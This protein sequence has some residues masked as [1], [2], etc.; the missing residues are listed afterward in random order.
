[1]FKKLLF[2]L[3]VLFCTVSYSQI[4]GKSVY[5]FLNLVTSPRQAALGGKIITN[6]DYDPNAALFNPASINQE[7]HNHLSVN[8]ANYYGE[9]TYGT[10]SYAYTYDR[11]LQTFHA[12]VNYVNYGDFEGVQFGG[13]M[14]K[15]KTSING[16]LT[17]V[18][19]FHK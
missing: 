1:M 11:H 17:F 13:S 4:G 9:V 19:V 14:N 10:A 5:Q 2:L 16:F 18:L 7:M 15:R 8:Y 3:F 6:F 12:G